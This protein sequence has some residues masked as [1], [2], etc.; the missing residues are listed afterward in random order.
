MVGISLA[1]DSLKESYLVGLAAC[2]A[3][4]LAAT[5][6]RRAVEAAAP[7]RCATMPTPAAPTTTRILFRPRALAAASPSASTIICWL[8]TAC[9]ASVVISGHSLQPRDRHE[10]SG[11]SYR[12]RPRT[13]GLSSPAARR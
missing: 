7:F 13:G 1:R 5:Q 11:R 4:L 9:S 2:Q 3:A 8:R 6:F 10:E 12:C